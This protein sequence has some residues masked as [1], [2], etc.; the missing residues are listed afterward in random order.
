MSYDWAGDWPVTG[1][2]H[3]A[4]RIA[5]ASTTINRSI[6]YSQRILS[7]HFQLKWIF[8]SRS[9]LPT[10]FQSRLFEFQLAIRAT[11]LKTVLKTVSLC[12]WVNWDPKI[13]QVVQNFGRS[14]KLVRSQLRR[15]TCNKDHWITT[16]WAAAF[17]NERILLANKARPTFR[18]ETIPELR[19][20]SVKLAWY[21]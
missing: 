20:S 19:S 11:V 18:L 16:F 4:L 5:F 2:Q 21:Y 8:E 14:P 10:T 9:S 3:V 6:W 1:D 13:A 15:L 7:Q 17:F 12:C